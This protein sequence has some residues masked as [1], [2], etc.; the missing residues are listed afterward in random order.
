[1]K[2]PRILLQSL[3]LILFATNMQAN[4]I[5]VERAMQLAR[6]FC[7]N[8]PSSMR[9][10]NGSSQ[11]KMVYQA[12]SESD[13]S[14]ADLYVFDRGNDEG[15]VIVSGNDATI[16]PVLGY[17]D[18]GRF[19]Y[20]SAPCNLKA[21]LKQYAGQIQYLRQHPEAN[22]VQPK[23]TRRALGLGNVVV[24]PLVKT[25][26]NQTTPYNNMCPLSY[27]SKS[28]TGCGPTAVAQ[29]LAYWKYPKQGRGSN[30]YYW[31]PTPTTRFDYSVDFSN[32]VYDWDNM[33]NSYA[34]GYN[35]KQADAVAL[36]MKDLGG[37]MKTIYGSVYPFG[38]GTAPFNV[39]PAL[40]K[41]FDYNGDS[42]QYLQRYLNVDQ[43]ETDDFDSYLK[44]DLDKKRP[45]IIG[46]KPAPD[47]L[48]HFMVVD[49]YTDTDYFHMN[50]GWEGEG[51]GYYLTIAIDTENLYDLENRRTMWWLEQEAVVGICPTY[52]TKVGD[53]YFYTADD[54][55]I[56]CHSEATDGAAT[57]PT[58]ITADGTTYPVTKIGRMA[59]YENEN[60][61]SIELPGS[62]KE[63]GERAFYN[64]SNLSVVTAP[65][66]TTSSY[67]T[68]T[69]PDQMTTMGKYAFARSGL[70]GITVP[71]SL[72][73]VTDY[74]FYR[75]DKL[76]EASIH[77]K[78]VGTM[79]FGRCSSK[80]EVYFAGETL[81]DGA[82]FYDGVSFIYLGNVKHIGNAC[83]SMCNFDAVTLDS[84]ETIG[85]NPGLV[86]AGGTINI[87][88]N[89]SIT[90]LRR[91]APMDHLV[92]T[93]IDKD[94][95]NFVSINN[96]VYSKDLKTLVHFGWKDNHI[97]VPSGIYETRNE[98]VI[99]ETVERIN[100]FAIDG[101]QF[102]Y[103]LTKMTI[104]A[105]VKEIGAGNFSDGVEVF[106]YATTPQLVKLLD[107][108][109]Y[110]GSTMEDELIDV[111]AQSYGFAK[112]T[113]EG[114][115][116]AA[117]SG[118]LHVPTGC[119]E[120]YEAAAVW[121]N[122]AKI[123]DDLPAAGSSQEETRAKG[124]RIVTDV[125]K[126]GSYPRVMYTY[127]FVFDTHPKLTYEHDK[128]EI[129][130]I[131][132]SDNIDIYAD[133]LFYKDGQVKITN[134]ALQKMEFFS[135]EN[136]D[137]LVPLKDDGTI[138]F[139]IDNRC[140]RV[141]GLEDGDHVELYTLDG[142]AVATAKSGIDGQAKIELPVAQTV[143]IL[144]AGETT[145]KVRVK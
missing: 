19:D 1:M 121:K 56:L 136:V 31:N 77:S 23:I 80:P 69:L 38:S 117:N 62:I 115:L 140:I 109:Y 52:S 25:T 118:T 39:E 144:K 6:Q 105:S 120:A 97:S 32:S 8:N 44:R 49:G 57:I 9:R 124:V 104:P 87:G 102:N 85:W 29:V 90:S 26:W 81:G 59:C 131:I 143:Y 88:K 139:T 110:E 58:S 79:A 72:V 138:R 41:Y 94:N 46:A 82:F 53:N 67:T 125:M 130:A 83:L 13:A 54:H 76:L 51:D 116:A 68:S 12:V 145:F 122:F 42:I 50:F 36:L 65:E 48:D 99:P 133:D 119:K 63:I 128:W 33:L 4:D 114:M 18:K 66:N 64:C 96:A 92:N 134:M 98:L 40:V 27:D 55:A 35:E 60:L 141:T 37:A 101:M 24:E 111:G 93:V 106:N 89:A 7:Q 70:T 137:G 86:K 84:I 14:K 28:Y 20:E 2:Q 47:L 108:S 127:E 45:V 123:V 100:D 73:R 17:S 74:A 142:K 95:P 126:L 11:L 21:L 5:S 135:D 132:S 71:A 91:S 34:G 10:A 78:E 3:L 129:H 103:R 75:C 22:A 112:E 113:V 107:E 16:T 15:F 61:T 30:N 43:G